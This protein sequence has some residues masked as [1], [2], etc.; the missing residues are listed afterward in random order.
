MRH[1]NFY[2][3]WFLVFLYRIITT[4][5]K[6]GSIRRRFEVIA[7]YTALNPSLKLTWQ[8]GQK[9]QA[10]QKKPQVTLK[11][12]S[13]HGELRSRYIVSGAINYKKTYNFFIL[14]KLKVKMASILCFRKRF[15]WYW[16]VCRLV[17]LVSKPLAGRYFSIAE[18][19]E[20]FF[21]WVLPTR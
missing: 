5:D 19:L 1:N 7:S 14:S 21:R 20:Q 15:Q 18:P 11:Q 3:S 13:W 16:R 17:K 9:K 10:N 2:A 8:K 4:N 12:R 6:W